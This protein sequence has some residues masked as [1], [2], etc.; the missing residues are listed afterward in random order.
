M[1][2][3]AV[4]DTPWALQKKGDGYVL[5]I[6]GRKG[7]KVA[8]GITDVT[9]DK[10]VIIIATTLRKWSVPVRFFSSDLI[11]DPETRKHFKPLYLDEEVDIFFSALDILIHPPEEDALDLLDE[12]SDDN[13]DDVPPSTEV[14]PLFN[15]IHTEPS[16]NDAEPTPSATESSAASSTPSLAVD[17]GEGDK[18]D[19]GD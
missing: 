8:G 9:L 13:D 3:V 18:G 12:L 10:N 6:Q 11:R 7:L 17:A 19:K 16:T 4:P 14:A 15:G 1:A 5:C 2:V